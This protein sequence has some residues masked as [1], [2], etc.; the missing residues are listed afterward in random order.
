M[1]EIVADPQPRNYR[2]VILHNGIPLGI[3]FLGDRKNALAFKR[4]IDH[5]VNLTSVSNHLFAQDFNLD[6]WL[7][8]QGVPPAVLDVVET[9]RDE[10]THTRQSYTAQHK[11]R[12]KM[13]RHRWGGWVHLYELTW[14]QYHIPE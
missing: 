8:K 6:E 1:Q 12:R 11:D 5:K 14:Y 9:G 10:S 3:L 7:H 2:K 4:A 13:C